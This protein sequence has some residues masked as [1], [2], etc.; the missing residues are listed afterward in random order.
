MK[1]LRLISAEFTES[2]VARLHELGLDVKVGWKMFEI[3]DEAY[4]RYL[5]IFKES[6]YFHD[7][8]VYDYTKKDI[9]STEYSIMWIRHTC[10]YPKPE[11]SYYELTYDSSKS[12]PKCA[13]EM[14]Q[15]AP[16]CIAKPP[17]FK[18]F[19][20]TA[21]VRDAVFASRE[22][23]DEV[24]KPFGIDSMPVCSYR[25]GP[26]KEAVQVVI[27]FL[28]EPVNMKGFQYTT[29]PECG[30]KKYVGGQPSPYFPIPEHI[31][32]GHI[33]KTMEYFGCGLEANHMI[34]VSAELRDRLIAD[35]AISW[36]NFAPCAKPSENAPLGTT[37]PR[38]LL[39]SH[40]IEK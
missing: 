21:W 34:I 18:L 37:G 26:R 30:A 12:C 38:T 28:D 32:A 7:E 22:Y 16:F 25:K 27:P 10:G 5:P 14:V 35:K 39:S 11:D 40:Q 19:G 33:F 6:S 24:L 17:K 13:V 20:F 15:K 1:T 29:C 31:G 8:L 2:Q 9:M 36:K 3:P 23:Y 4:C